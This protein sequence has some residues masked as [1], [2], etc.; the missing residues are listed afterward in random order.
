MLSPVLGFSAGIM[1]AV[2]AFD[3]MPEAF[4]VASIGWGLLGLAA[5]A[6]LLAAADLLLPHMH[7]LSSDEESQRFLRTGLLIGLGI[8]IHNLPEGLAIGAGF[9]SSL[10]F[11]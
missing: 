7:F 10:E 5:G 8:A 3:L 11:G 6:G 1:L 2:V 9:G 4:A